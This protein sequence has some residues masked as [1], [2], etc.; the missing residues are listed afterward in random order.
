MPSQRFGSGSPDR[1][2]ALV[3]EALHSNSINMV[4]GLVI[5]ALFVTITGVSA[6]GSRCSS[7]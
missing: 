6:A 5:P 7:P 4:G 2:D 1:G 3:S